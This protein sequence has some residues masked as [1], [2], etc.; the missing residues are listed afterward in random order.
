MES[1]KKMDPEL[2]ARWVAALRSGDYQQVRGWLRATRSDGQLGFCCLGVLCEV[3]GLRR[4]VGGE[5]HSFYPELVERTPGCDN[6]RSR[7]EL[8]FGIPERVGV[9]LATQNDSGR[10]FPETADWIEENL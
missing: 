8:L 3:A 2:K 1:S 10:E 4:S 5:S 7:F 9:D 6:W